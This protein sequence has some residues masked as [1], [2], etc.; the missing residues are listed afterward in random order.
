MRPGTARVAREAAARSSRRSMPSARARPI[1]ASALRTLKRPGSAIET[2]TSPTPERR[3]VAFAA[4]RLCACSVASAIERVRDRRRASSRGE[5]RARCVVDVEHRERREV[6][7][8]ALRRDVAV[9]RAVEVEVVARDVRQRGGARSAR[10]RRGAARAR[11]TT[12]PSRPRA[13][14]RRAARRAARAARARAASCS[15]RPR[16]VAERAAERADDAARDAG[17]F[18][19]VAHEMRRRRLAVGAGDADDGELVR[20]VVVERVRERRRGDARV[21]DGDGGWRTLRRA[22]GD[23]G[24]AGF[25]DDDDRRAAGDRVAR[26]SAWPSVRS[27]RSATNSVPGSTARESVAIASTDGGSV[28]AT[29]APG[30]VATRRGRVAHQRAS[31]ARAPRTARGRKRCAGC[32]GEG[33]HVA[34]VQHRG[35]GERRR[36][37]APRPAAVDRAVG[38]LD[39]H[40]DH[41]ARV[42]GR[43]HADERRDVRARQVRAVLDHLRRAG[44]ARGRVAGHARGRVARAAQHDGA[45][46]RAQRRRGLLRHHAALGLAAV[47]VD[48]RAV[49][50]LDRG[51]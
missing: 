27:P 40:Q 39:L 7:Q 21:R 9:E 34:G 31:F 49:G 33:G 3:A 42:L 37:R 22:Q 10:R 32:G 51:R 48:Q 17:G 23:I 14:P 45:Q 11:A 36:T 46:E 18:E 1:A 41:V 28:P 47:A 25:F 8:P 24:R 20:R 30:R 43:D 15:K 29:R 6:E 16:A 38:A 35:A 44:L 26:R 13:R 19:H 5:R 2:S 50:V 4:R 12:L